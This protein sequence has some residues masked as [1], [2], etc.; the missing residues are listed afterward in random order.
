MRLLIA[1]TNADKLREYR[2]LLKGSDFKIYQLPKKLRSLEVEENGKTFTDN[3][4]IKAKI[5]GQKS[6]RL[7]LCDDTGLEIKAL[8]G[9]P[10]LNSHRFAGQGF[11][12]ARKELLRRLKGVPEE[13]RSARFVCVI[14]L[15]FPET[16]KIKTFTGV[17][18]GF[19]TDKE[20]GGRGFGYDPIFFVPGENKTFAQMNLS[21]K[22]A[23]SHRGRAVAKLKSWYNH[24]RI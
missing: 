14:A 11:P 8:G 15:Y 5:Y 19:I 24:K 18:N 1:T 9:F 16:G 2:Q 6:G 4:V 21:R 12:H 3:A 7:T 13:K 20:I 17:V 23:L 22:N 10:G